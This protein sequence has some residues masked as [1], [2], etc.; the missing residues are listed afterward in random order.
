MKDSASSLSDQLHVTGY[1]RE[2]EYFFEKNRALIER[3]RQELDCQRQERASQNAAKA[4]WMTCP[5]CGG[6]LQE[7]RFLGL[8]GDSCQKCGGAFFDHDEV[9]R[10]GASHEPHEFKEAVKRLFAA[11]LKPRPTGLGQFPV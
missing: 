8:T 4:F 7:A 11:A 6:R 5:K 10:L 9:A 3:N 2:E 1:D